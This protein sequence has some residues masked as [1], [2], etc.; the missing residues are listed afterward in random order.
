MGNFPGILSLNIPC[1]RKHTQE[2]W[3][4][5]RDA[6]GKQV[7]ATSLESRYPRKMCVAL[8]TLVLEVAKSTRPATESAIIA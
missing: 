4:F 8:V 2:P 5:A 3:G 7:W 6:D 1:D